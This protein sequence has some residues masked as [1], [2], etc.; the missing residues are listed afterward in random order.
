MN[1][2]RDRCAAHP[3]DLVGVD[4]W[5]RALDGGGQVE[6]DLS[7]RTRLPDVHHC[8]AYLDSEIEFGVD[9]NLRRV[10]VAE[11]LGRTQQPL[12][13][14]HH[15]PSAIGGQRHRLG[16]AVA[17]H[18]A[19]KQ[20]RR[21]VVQVH[22][23]VR[24][25]DQ[26]LHGA[27]DEVFAGLRQDRNRDVG[28]HLAVLDDAA[29]EIKIRLRRRGE[30]DLDFLVT[31]PHQQLKHRQLA[32]RAHRVDQG[33]VAVAKVGRQPPRGFRDDL[34]RPG[35]VRQIDRR[36][37]LVFVDRH[38]ARALRDDAPGRIAIAAHCCSSFSGW[39]ITAGTQQ[40]RDEETGLFR[41]SRRGS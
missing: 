29:N 1:S 38:L 19:P 28:R 10:L 12:G 7:T 34:R 36:P 9:E 13:V 26:A 11:G 16:R 15:V 18:H 3:L 25:A 2:R 33:L 31:H 37:W 39:R 20:R 30:P 24:R 6:D 8:F 32:A 41:G 35:A 40:S 22:G 5:R 27:L 17:E 14:L 21:R 23:R 4:V